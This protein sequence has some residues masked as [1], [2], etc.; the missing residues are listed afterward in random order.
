MSSQDANE[1]KGHRRREGR[2]V[3]RLNAAA[4]WQR[5]ALLNRNQSWLAREVGISH[6]YLSMLVNTGRAPS[7]RI[8]SRMQKALGVDDFHE[9]FNT[10]ERNDNH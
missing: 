8:R 5:V 10:E 6:G 4:L 2:A 7:G 3:V 9:L 1:A